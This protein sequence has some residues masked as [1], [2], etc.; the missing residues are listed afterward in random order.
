MIGPSIED[1]ITL[2]VDD[3]ASLHQREVGGLIL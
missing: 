3:L 2:L 1:A